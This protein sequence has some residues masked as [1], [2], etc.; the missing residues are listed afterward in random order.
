MIYGQLFERFIWKQP[1]DLAPD[2]FIKPKIALS[3]AVVNQK[4]ASKLKIKFQ[5]ADFFFTERR[6]F[7]IAGHIDKGILKEA[8]IVSANVHGLDS[9][10]DTGAFNKLPHQTLAGI[11]SGIPVAAVVLKMHKGKLRC[12]T[13]GETFTGKKFETTDYTDYTD[14]ESEISVVKSLCFVYHFG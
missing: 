5:V 10:L 14:K 9:R 8:C 1:F 6:K 3:N 2:G 4:G 11:R 12:L 13:H 7:L